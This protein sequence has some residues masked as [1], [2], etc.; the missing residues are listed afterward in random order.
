MKRSNFSIRLAQ[1]ARIFARNCLSMIHHYSLPD[2]TPPSYCSPDRIFF[3]FIILFQTEKKEL[4][5]VKKS[6]VWNFVS[7]ATMV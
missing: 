2:L 6:L 5:K 4:S 3:P 7:P 1:V